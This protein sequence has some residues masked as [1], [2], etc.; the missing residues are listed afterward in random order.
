[1]GFFDSIK[2]LFGFKRKKINTEF[3]EQKQNT[4]S[5]YEEIFANG[6]Y[7]EFTN[8]EDG[9]LYGIRGIKICTYVFDNGM[10][11]YEE[12]VPTG[13]TA[14][15][16]F[17]G[18]PCYKFL[19][20]KGSKFNFKTLK[21]VTDIYGVAN[22]VIEFENNDGYATL[23]VPQQ[24]ETATQEGQAVIDECFDLIQQMKNARIASK[25]DGVQK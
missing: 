3:N 8:L 1:M 9:A 10:V 19:T 23:S 25:E 24:S 15:V 6:Y 2:E 16:D 5:T 22:Y 4:I 12:T 13:S 11:I 18:Y 7:E 21:K 17:E 14:I 20:K